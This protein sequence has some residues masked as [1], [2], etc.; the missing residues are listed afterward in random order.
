MRKIFLHHIFN[1]RNGYE[2]Y[3]NVYKKDQLICK[4]YNIL[5]LKF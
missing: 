3:F 1:D 5:Y 4:L 2:V